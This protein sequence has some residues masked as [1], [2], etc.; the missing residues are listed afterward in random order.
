[1]TAKIRE[2]LEELYG[3][4]WDCG[5]GGVDEEQPAISC[6]DDALTAIEALMPRWVKCSERLIDALHKGAKSGDKVANTAF[7]LA[8]EVTE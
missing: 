3:K 4:A 7:Y 6:I 5:K 8:R 1:M 2:V